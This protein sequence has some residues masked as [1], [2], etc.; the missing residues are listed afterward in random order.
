MSQHE[1]NS[2]FL[3]FENVFNAII[4]LLIRYLWNKSV[5]SIGDISVNKFLFYPEFDYWSS[6]LNS[7]R[8]S[9]E[10]SL[11]VLFAWK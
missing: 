9:D 4:S 5:F 11:Q 7:K 3:V 8:K 10:S 1:L 6:F 2:L